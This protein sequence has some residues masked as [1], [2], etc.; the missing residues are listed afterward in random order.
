MH[1]LIFH[2]KATVFNVVLT[3]VFFGETT[4]IKAIGCCSMIISG[5]LLGID[6]ENGLGKAFYS[7]TGLVI[8]L[9]ISGYRAFIYSRELFELSFLN[10]Q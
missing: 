9:K 3:H 5:F 6:Q 2:V 10:K 1:N 4:S 7:L 8:I